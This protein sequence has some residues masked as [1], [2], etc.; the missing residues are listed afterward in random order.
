MRGDIMNDNILRGP[1]KSESWKRALA[2]GLCGCLAFGGAS[3][4]FLGSPTAPEGQWGTVPAG[5]QTAEASGYF[6][7]GP[8]SNVK[9]SN[10]TV[11]KTTVRWRD[12]KTR[13]VKK[14]RISYYSRA[15]LT[16]KAPSKRTRTGDKSWNRKSFQVKLYLYKNWKWKCVKTIKTDRTSTYLPLVY[17][18]RYKVSISVW[19][20]PADASYNWKQTIEMGSNF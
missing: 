20:G 2:L 13:K 4:L 11:K 3:A 7:Y 5:V 18:G 9:F 10:R 14:D 19:S 12:P 1:Q 17:L 16:W 6:W 8:V 15:F